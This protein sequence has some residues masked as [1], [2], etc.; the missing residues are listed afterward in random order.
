VLLSI[1]MTQCHKSDEECNPAM[2]E[3]LDSH[4]VE[5]V[6]DGDDTAESE[7]TGTDPRW[8]ALKKLKEQ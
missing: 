8:E 3:M 4:R 5:A 2:L 7:S 1:P 6:P